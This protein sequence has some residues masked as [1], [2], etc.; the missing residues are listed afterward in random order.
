[1]GL[2]YK[3]DNNSLFNL[4]G[5][6]EL[7]PGGPA[8]SPGFSGLPVPASRFFSIFPGGQEYSKGGGCL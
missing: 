1:V 5:Y 4:F 7:I 3:Y 2:D 8:F 6:K